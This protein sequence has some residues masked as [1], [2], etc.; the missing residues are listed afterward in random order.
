MVACQPPLAM[1]APLGSP[2]ATTTLTG[3]ATFSSGARHTQAALSEVGNG[4][5]VSLIDATTG[6]TISSTVTD[7]SGSFILTFTGFNPTPNAP[8]V[9]EAI[10]GLSVG[11]ASNRAGAKAASIRSLL[12]YNGGWQSLTN[13]TPGVGIVVSP[14]TTALCVMT[15]LRSVPAASLSALIQSTNGSTYTGTSSSPFTSFPTDF[16]GVTTLVSNAISLDQDPV[17]AIGFDSVAATYSLATGVPVVTGAGPSL[18]TPGGSVLLRGAYLDPNAGRN[19]FWFGSVYAPTW[20]VSADRTAATVSIPAGAYSA[21]LTMQQ[22]NGVV[23]TLIPYLMLHGTVGTLAGNPATGSVDGVGLNTSFSNPR[24]LAFDPTTG[25]LY[26]ADTDNNKIRKITPGGV[27]TT[28]AGTGTAGWVD[29]AGATAQFN[30]PRGVAVDG[31]GNVYVADDLNYILRK[32]T[33]A[34]VV[35]TFA[36]TG[37]PGWLDGPGGSAQFRRPF[38]IT[39]D[40]TNSVLYV[41]DRN[42][43]MVR[44][45]TLGGAVTTLAGSASVGWGVSGHVDGTGT[46][47]QFSYPN[48]VAV[49]GAGNVF[50]SEDGCYIRKITAAG[51][52]T[53]YAG[54]GVLASL[55]GATSSAEFYYPHGLA[56]DGGGNVYVADHYGYRIRK[57]T[58]AGSVTTVAGTGAGSFADGATSSAQ[59]YYPDGIAFDASGNLFIGDSANNRIR[60]LTP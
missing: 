7:A 11:G 10:K 37:V 34:G 18:A 23:Q 21:P 28:F 49:D 35:S 33:P 48:E 51:V 50:E 15:S 26:L 53:T 47:A 46:N 58:L 41:G 5:S 39:Y 55:D 30:G 43:C 52:V 44:K 29:G 12:F 36:G 54:N 6:N 60:T 3:R 25:N 42:N 56:V 14:A 31:A 22:P 13:T 16:P 17:S 20:T 27:V 2:V 1:R 59:F 24:G 57:I 32:I 38:A 8:Y 19:T 40:A 9:L 45:V 4:A